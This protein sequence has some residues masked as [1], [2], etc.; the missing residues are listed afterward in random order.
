MPVV[1]LEVLP[2]FSVVFFKRQSFSTSVSFKMGM[3]M[4]M[5][6]NRKMLYVFI[7]CFTCRVL[8]DD[9]WPIPYKYVNLVNYIIRNDI[10]TE[11]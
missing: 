5:Y 8:A 10:G 2:P 4:T 7:I 9:N 6:T 11:A 1:N 3:D